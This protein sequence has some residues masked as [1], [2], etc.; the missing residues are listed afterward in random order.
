M[1]VLESGNG[2]GLGVPEPEERGVYEPVDIADA[3]PFGLGPEAASEDDRELG[4]GVA[5]AGAGV[6]VVFES[7]VV[8][9]TPDGEAVGPVL[10][11][12]APLG[13]ESDVALDSG[14]GTEG[15]AVADT[16]GVILPLLGAVETVPDELPRAGDDMA[17]ADREV[18]GLGGTV[19]G[20][21]APG[22]ELVG[23]TVAFMG[24]IEV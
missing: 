12:G 8:E 1:L 4:D 9:N 2:A 7:G 19:N 3:V 11:P 15:E 24:E 20:A 16:E 22:A 5:V 13:P 6:I 18:V 17:V 10:K 23:D 14:K 21:G